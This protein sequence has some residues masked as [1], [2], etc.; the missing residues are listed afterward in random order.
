M[1]QL[2]TYSCDWVNMTTKNKKLLI[3]IIM[4]SQ[5]P[6]QLTIGQMVVVSLHTFTEVRNVAA[7]YHFIIT[8]LYLLC[9]VHTWNRLPEVFGN[10]G[11]IFV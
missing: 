1:V 2:S 4:R 6:L 11:F 10:F 9:S 3:I 8:C 7:V 5:R